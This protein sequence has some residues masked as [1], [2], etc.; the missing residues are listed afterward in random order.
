MYC[1]IKQKEDQARALKQAKEVQ[2]LMNASQKDRDKAGVKKGE[3]TRE[4]NKRKQKLGQANFT[5]KDDRDVT[6]PLINQ[7]NEDYVQK[8]RKM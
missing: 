3:T 1:Q 5:L 4:K 2:L 8:R 6:N 7:S